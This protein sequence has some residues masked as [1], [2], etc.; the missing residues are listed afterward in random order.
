MGAVAVGLVSGSLAAAQ[1][2]LRARLD[3][4]LD[5]EKGLP[6]CEPSQKGWF[7]DRPQAH[8]Q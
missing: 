7:F 2:D 3:L 4:E 1:R 6:W 8:H 5:G